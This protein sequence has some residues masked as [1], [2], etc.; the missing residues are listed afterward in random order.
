MFRV[1]SGRATSAGGRQSEE[2]K[3]QRK[4]VE[5][6]AMDAVLA[7]ERREKRSPKDVSHKKLGYDIESGDRRIE[8]KG[9]RE[10]KGDITLTRNEWEAARK[11]RDQF[12]VY[13]VD[14]SKN[15]LYIISN[16]YEKADQYAM[17]NGWIHVPG[18][19]EVD[20]SA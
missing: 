7:Y 17:D 12:Y 10:W 16:P 8:V 1:R 4:R 20:L 3:R 2:E 18:T 14:L 6:Q 11:Y 19:K 13:V 5:E 15:K 9:T